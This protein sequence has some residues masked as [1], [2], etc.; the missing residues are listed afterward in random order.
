MTVKE[1]CAVI[2]EASR[3]RIRKDMKDVYVG[4]LGV[5]KTDSSMFGSIQD[6]EV[7]R[8]IA[9]PE[10]RHRQWQQRK[11]M[12]PLL[13]KETPDYSFSDLQLTLYYTIEI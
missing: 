4:F 10:L 11:L 2:S 8:F 3:L 1:F 6:M 7:K 5:L 9:D 13:P 12:K